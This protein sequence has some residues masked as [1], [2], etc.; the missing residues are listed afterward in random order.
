MRLALALVLAQVSGEPAAAE[1]ACTP[2]SKPVVVAEPCASCGEQPLRRKR[3]GLQ[4]GIV[5]RNCCH[6]NGSWYGTCGS[7]KAVSEGRAKRTFS[8]G[9]LACN[10]RPMSSANASN[11]EW[12]SGIQAELD[13]WDEWMASKGGDR[14][15]KDYDRRLDPLTP[16]TP[17]IERVLLKARAPNQTYFRMLD[18]GS[19]PLEG[20]GFVFGSEPNLKLEVQATDAL[21]SAY[22][23]LLDKHGLRPPVRVQQLLG[24][25]LTQRFG[26]NQFDLVMCVNALD[27]TQDPIAVLTQMLQVGTGLRMA[28]E[29][30]R[31][32]CLG[33]LLFRSASLPTP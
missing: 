30:L 22:Q 10:S 28:T 9:H 12:D 11:E 17:S 25:Q 20:S 16:L 1:I 13:Y 24:E 29:G 14:F 21:G 6:R 19:G 5:D 15:H 27:H 32:S 23:R 26:S 4:A 2:N 8:A 3:F 31:S 33:H 18:V 7:D